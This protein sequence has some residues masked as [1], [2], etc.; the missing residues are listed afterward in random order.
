[1]KRLNKKQFH[2]SEKKALLL[3]IAFLFLLVTNSTAI[4]KSEL[5]DVR[6]TTKPLDLSRTPTTKELM[7]AGQLGGQLFPTADIAVAA[8][9]AADKAG[10]EAAK[11]K[12][13]GQ[14]VARKQ[15]SRNQAINLS[16]GKAIQAWN[17]HEYKDAVGM[18]EEHMQE[19]PDSPWAAESALHIGCDARYSGR[20]TEATEQFN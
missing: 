5:A 7:A 11:A 2:L 4:A 10:D 19:F 6:L 20:Y 13:S 12:L 8:D 15:L 9:E 14:S 3:L 16:F 18:F 17:K 1:M